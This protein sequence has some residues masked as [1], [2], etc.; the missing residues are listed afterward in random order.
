MLTPLLA[1]S[2][3]ANYMTNT[4]TVQTILL[5]WHPVT[6]IDYIHENYA[7]IMLS[8]PLYIRTLWRYRN[9]I[10]IIIIQHISEGILGTN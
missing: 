6:C 4:R 10:I 3:E 1:M 9:C 2:Y 8:A 5:H 7:S